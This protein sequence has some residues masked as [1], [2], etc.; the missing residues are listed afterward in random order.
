MSDAWTLAYVL[1]ASRPT[2]WWA[3]TLVLEGT[4]ETCT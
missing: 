4:D 3:A 1:D 2:V